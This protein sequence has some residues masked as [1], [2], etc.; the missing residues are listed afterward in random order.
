[1]ANISIATVSRVINGK[2]GVRKKTEQC[3]L[4]AIDELN[5]IPDVIARSMINK[6]T[7][8]IGV[9]VPDITNPFFPLVISGIE[10]QARAKGYA[11]MLCNS[12][13]SPEIEKSI[14][15]V[16]LERNIDGLIITTADEE[17]SQL[18]LAIER[19]V[20][21]IAVDRLIKNYEIDA[22]IINNADG[23]YQATKH[24]I[25]QG[26]NR[27]AIISGPYNTTPGYERFVGYRKALEEYKIPLL[28]EYVLQGD[29]KEESGNRITNALY[30]SSHRPTA[31]FSANNLMTVGCL[32]ALIALGW[33][34]GDEVSLVGFDDIDIATFV[35]PQLTVVSRPM[36]QLGEIAFNILYEK[37]NSGGEWVKRHSVLLP[38]LKI[39]QSC[40]LKK[41]T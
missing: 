7:K 16:L 12:N 30:S 1:M 5:Y 24:L 27:I 32:K 10:Q 6:S 18:Q 14:V 35:E 26:H 3:V 4:R 20:P 37:I 19:G 28:N 29:F 17:G 9:I 13:E 11:T 41:L 34:L 23:A 25:L 36:R 40:I 33:K 38:E 8:T 15:K 21:I 2:G 31:I 39:R 22:V